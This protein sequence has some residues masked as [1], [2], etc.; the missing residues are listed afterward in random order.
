MFKGY[1]VKYGKGCCEDFGIV[2]LEEGRG[3]SKC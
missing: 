2:D 3:S 1:R